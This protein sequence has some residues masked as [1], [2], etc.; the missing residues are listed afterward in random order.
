MAVIIMGL[1]SASGCCDPL[2]GCLSL[3]GGGTGVGVARGARDAGLGVE[4]QEL[5]SCVPTPDPLPPV[6]GG[7]NA[8]SPPPPFLAFLRLPGSGRLKGAAFWK[9]ICSLILTQHP[10]WHKLFREMIS[11]AAEKHWG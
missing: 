4:G 10:A 2:Q 5:S 8:P 1:P 11:R 3:V 7:V 6:C 9:L